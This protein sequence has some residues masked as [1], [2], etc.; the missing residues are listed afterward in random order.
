MDCKAARTF[1]ALAE[2]QLLMQGVEAKPDADWLGFAIF[3]P[4]SDNTK[5]HYFSL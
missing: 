1:L 2:G 3:K 4:I 5:G